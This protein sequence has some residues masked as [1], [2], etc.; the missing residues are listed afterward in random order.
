[1]RK[2]WKKEKR[3][4]LEGFRTRCLGNL[5]QWATLMV[6]VGIVCIIL[7]QSTRTTVIVTDFRTY[8]QVTPSMSL[9]SLFLGCVRDSAL[10]SCVRP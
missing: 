10:P 3:N 2:G 4:W 7:L 8:L 9:L 1:M 6:V 5:V